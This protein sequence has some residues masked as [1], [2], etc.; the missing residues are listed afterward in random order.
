MYLSILALPL[1]GAASA[2]LLGRK[3]GVTGAQ[4]VTTVCMC[5]S[6]LLSIVAFYEVALCGSSVSI[7]LSSWIDSGLMSVDWAF[8]FDSLTVSMLLPVTC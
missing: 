8:M 2:G 6:A 5:S 1:L 7:Y 4:I 3:L